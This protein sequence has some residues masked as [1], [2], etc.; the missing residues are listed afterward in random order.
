MPLDELF[1]VNAKKGNFSVNI[2][3]IAVFTLLIIGIVI[4]MSMVYITVIRISSRSLTLYTI[5]YVLILLLVFSISFFQ[6]NLFA[7]LSVFFILNCVIF[8]PTLIFECWIFAKKR[9]TKE[10]QNNTNCCEGKFN[11]LGESARCDY[12]KVKEARIEV[13]TCSY[14]NQATSKKR[15]YHFLETVK[16]I[17]KLTFLKIVKLSK[18]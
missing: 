5:V 15:N 9:I 6:L 4:C 10:N 1:Y 11:S 16:K 18:W 12:S 14:D 8:F 3:F 7:C 13:L 2:L 17:I